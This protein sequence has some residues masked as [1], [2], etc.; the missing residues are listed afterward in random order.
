MRPQV[1][2]LWIGLAIGVPAGIVLTLVLGLAAVVALGTWMQS[3]MG[4]RQ[5]PVPLLGAEFPEDGRRTVYG[6]TDYDWPL[7]TLD[8]EEASFAQF[9]GRTVFLNVW[10]TWCGPCVSE[11]PSIEK[12]HRSISDDGI[13]VILVTAESP[14]TVRDFM[15][16]KGF[17]LPVYLTPGDVPAEFAT[18][19][20]PAT[21][22]VDPD[23]LILFRHVGAA[24]WDDDACREFLRSLS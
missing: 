8:G 16:S 22:V 13:A 4:R 24:D 19:G 11:M 12:L 15:G 3:Q 14:E 9:R 2:G 1:K 10:A 6:R 23:G 5:L 21:F 7:L 18:P 20:V 17:H